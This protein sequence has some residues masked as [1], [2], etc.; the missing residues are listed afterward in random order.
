[1]FD[2]HSGFSAIWTRDDHLQSGSQDGSR[3]PSRT[4][5]RMALTSRQRIFGASRSWPCQIYRPL[6]LEAQTIPK[7][8]IPNPFRVNSI[9]TTYNPKTQT[10]NRKT[11]MF[12]GSARARVEGDGLSV[13]S[14]HCAG[15]CLREQNIL[16]Q[17]LRAHTGF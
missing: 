13:R 1:M 4:C 12:C 6:T 16:C 8:K 15:G 11:F 14:W 2:Q 9:P 5:S 17:R 3:L 10:L 7:L